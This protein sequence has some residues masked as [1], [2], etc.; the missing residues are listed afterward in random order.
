MFEINIFW[1]EDRR[2]VMKFY[3]WEDVRCVFCIHIYRIDVPNLGTTYLFICKT[4]RKLCLS[5]MF[6]EYNFESLA[7]FVALNGT[8][9][10]HNPHNTFIEWHYHTPL[11]HGVCSVH[12]WKIGIVNE[13]RILF[14]R[15]WLTRKWLTLWQCM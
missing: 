11:I 14:G 6:L 8:V 9:N 13:K 15:T 1:V 7:F 10:I 3:N 12:N 2:R 5:A 4:D